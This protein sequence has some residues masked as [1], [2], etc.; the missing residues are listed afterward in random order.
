MVHAEGY[1]L[2]DAEV[3][4]VQTRN[5]GQVPFQLKNDQISLFRGE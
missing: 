1:V 5:Y 4:C 3:F 2:H